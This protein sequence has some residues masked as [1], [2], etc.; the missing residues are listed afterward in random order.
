MYDCYDRLFA[1][2]ERVDEL[3]ADQ[4]AKN[5]YWHLLVSIYMSNVVV[6]GSNGDLGQWVVGALS[7]AGWQVR[8][9]D[10]SHPT[11]D[12][13][14]EVTAIE[15]DLTDTGETLEAILAADPDAVVHLA[16]VGPQYYAPSR[17]YGN[18]TL[19]A[20]H[21][22]TAAG[23]VGADIVWTSSEAVYGWVF[24]TGQVL[25]DEL[26]VRVEHSCRP[27]NQYG[28]S[29]VAAEVTAEAVARR[30]NV[31]VTTIRPSWIQYPGTYEC[32]DSDGEDLVG[33]FWSYVDVRDIVRLIQAALESPPEG[34]TTV[35]AAAIDNYVGRPTCELFADAF[36]TVPA[37]C[38]IVGT[39][40]ALS[41]ANAATTFD[42]EPKHTY[43]QAATDDVGPWDP[44]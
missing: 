3:N 21:A 22:L 29:K 20:Y 23:R 27:R 41:T 43:H 2:H 16:A 19:A 17:V 14:A 30:Y 18:N 36:E 44:W 28:V 24:A 32:T 13:P 37:P 38:D 25:P 35:Q 33:N 1:P 39:E 8:C 4:R 15:T 26:P 31:S 6:T 42:W 12:L 40:S 9:L 5:Y 7:R 34:E 10:H 11:A